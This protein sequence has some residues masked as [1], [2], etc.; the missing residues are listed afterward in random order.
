MHETII[1]NK[2]IQTASE[3]GKVKSMTVE[4]GDLAELS[5]EE[6]EESLTKLANC[7]VRVLNKPAIVKCLC[8]YQGEPNIRSRDHDNVIFDCPRC[9][10]IPPVLE[11][12]DI[13]LKEVVVE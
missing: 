13:I 9:H 2:I 7:E 5:K 4:V 12:K 3:H 8:G 6:L 10:K 11:G 1:A